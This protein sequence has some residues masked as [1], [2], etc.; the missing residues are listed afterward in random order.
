[1]LK[2]G[3]F[4]ALTGI[5]I[6]ML[7]NYDKIGLLRPEQVDRINNYRFYCEKQIVHA[8]YIQTLKSLGF[9][10]NDIS[11][12]L[13][14]GTVDDRIKMFLE[15]KIIEK[16]ENLQNTVSQI[17][18]MRQALKELDQKNAYTLSI[19]VKH[20]PAR[21]V[22]SLRDNIRSFSEEGLLWERL[23]RACKKQNVKFADMQ[24]SFAMTHDVDFEKPSIDTEVFR[25][26][27]RL[28]SCAG[29]LKF[30]EIPEMEAAVVAFEGIYNHIGEINSYIYRWSIENGYRL[31]G[32]AYNIYYLSPDNEPNPE[33]FVTE[34]CFPIKK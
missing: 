4:S 25:V 33:K 23:N 26:V 9:G 18:K 13:E 24:Y 22:V 31:V 32:K 7:R 14:C 20:L 19:S 2:I 17:A 28:E 15:N 3:E 29:E 8:N 10:L 12:I 21:K 30:S 11:R 1:M 16:E 5:S 6:H 27:E 34:I